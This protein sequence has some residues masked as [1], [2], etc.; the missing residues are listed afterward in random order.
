[1]ETPSGKLLVAGTAPDEDH[2]R[3]IEGMI[4]H[5]VTVKR[6][7]TLT[8][9]DRGPS[10]GFPEASDSLNA[11]RGTISES[12]SI[13]DEKRVPKGFAVAQGSPEGIHR[14]S[15]VN[16]ERFV[17]DTV[18]AAEASEVKEFKEYPALEAHVR[19]PNQEWYNLRAWADKEGHL[20]GKLEVHGADGSREK[21][22]LNFRENARGFGATVTTADGDKRFIGIQAQKVERDGKEYT[23][24]A[25]T[26]SAMVPGEDG[27]TQFVP[28]SE[29]PGRVRMNE[30]MA[31]LQNPREVQILSDKLGV[32]RRDV[33]PYR[34][35][36]MEQSA[37]EVA[38]PAAP[39]PAAR[40][41]EAPVQEAYAIRQEKTIGDRDAGADHAMWSGKVV[42]VDRDKQSID[43]ESKVGGENAVTRVHLQAP[44]PNGVEVGKDQKIAFKDG[45]YTVTPVERK[46]PGK[47]MGR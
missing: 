31:E 14:M 13:G 3:D 46:A 41:P 43:M 45:G 24:V 42:G 33:E 9:V 8:L 37:P 18:M 19:G 22:D 7:R 2:Q 25:M 34:G 38:A 15:G 36:K 47:E 6:R 23:N 11:P 16:V 40:T 29:K 27:K 32:S 5:E 30:A 21:L 44:V 10:K 4:G 17:E 26:A 12:P 28:L 39:E 35:P 1:L 20:K